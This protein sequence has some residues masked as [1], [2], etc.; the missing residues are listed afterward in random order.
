[1]RPARKSRSANASD[2]TGELEIAIGL[3]KRPGTVMSTSKSR[4]WAWVTG[5]GA[6]EPRT[7]GHG[8]L[9]N[10]VLMQKAQLVDLREVDNHYLAIGRVQPGGSLVNYVGAAW[11]SSRDVTRVEDWWEIVDSFAQRLGA[12]VIVEVER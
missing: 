9:G 4:D 7:R 6:I 3:V 5:W 8:D 11:T 10:A 1:M 12:R 2:R